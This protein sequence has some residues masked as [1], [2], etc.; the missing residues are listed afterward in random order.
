M[1]G[2]VLPARINFS[3]CALGAKLLFFGG[4]AER[5]V[6][7]S[8]LHVVDLSH[9]TPFWQKLTLPKGA[10]L[11]AGRWGHSLR[12]VSVRAPALPPHSATRV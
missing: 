6:A 7:L 12:T 1:A 4:E 9:P 11:P 2:E 3:M 10:P 8:D 5:G